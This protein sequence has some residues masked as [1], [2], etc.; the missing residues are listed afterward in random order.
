[1]PRALLFAA[2]FLAACGNPCQNVCTEMARYAEE[3]GLTVSRD[4]ILVCRDAHS[5][6]TDEEIDA[7]RTYSDPDA[8]REWWTCDDLAENYQQGG[9]LP[10]E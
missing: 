9:G 8:L 5:D 1:M 3:C 4:D 2:V 10:S 6:A 7:C